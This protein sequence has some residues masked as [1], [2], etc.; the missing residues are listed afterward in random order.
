MGL[1]EEVMIETVDATDWEAV[2]RVLETEGL[3]TG[4]GVLNENGGVQGKA[5]T[6]D[7][8]HI[9]NGLMDEGGKGSLWRIE[10]LAITAA[11]SSEGK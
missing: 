11:E 2:V 6:R 8:W 3:G 4:V 7:A 10:G 1:E 5:G 9:D